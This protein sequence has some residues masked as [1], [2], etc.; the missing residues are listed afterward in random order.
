MFEES[1]R[2]SLARVFVAGMVFGR[3][4]YNLGRMGQFVKF[5]KFVNHGFRPAAVAMVCLD[6]RENHDRHV[7]SATDSVSKPSA[8]LQGANG[9]TVKDPIFHRPITANRIRPLRDRK[10][11]LLLEQP[12]ARQHLVFKIGR[13]FA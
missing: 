3:L 13:I 7:P 5:V 1:F 12:A 8:V 2:D 10:S 6:L 9:R 11:A 4:R